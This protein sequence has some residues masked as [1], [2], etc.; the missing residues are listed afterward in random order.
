MENKHG[1]L[2]MENKHGVLF[3]EFK[4]KCPEDV[5]VAKTWRTG[6]AFNWVYT[7][8]SIDNRKKSNANGLGS[9]D[10]DKDSSIVAQMLVSCRVFHVKKKSV[11]E[12][13]GSKTPK[14]SHVGLKEETLGLDGNRVSYAWNKQLKKQPDKSLGPN[15]R[16]PHRSTLQRPQLLPEAGR[17]NPTRFSTIIPN[18]AIKTTILH[19]CDSSHTQHPLPLD[20]ASLER[21]VREQ[22]DKEQEKEN[23]IRVLKKELL[24]AMADNPPVIF[25]HVATELGPRVNHFNSGAQ[26]QQGVR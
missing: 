24:D 13:D 21:H 17:W 26:S 19:W 7:F 6:N 18:L 23:L 1:N 11:C 12:L 2:R 9:H 3:F 16:T 10:F 5:L 20:Y 22:K 4:V 14:A 25:S 8:H 15:L